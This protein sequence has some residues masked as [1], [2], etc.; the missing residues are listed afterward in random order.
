[1]LIALKKDKIFIKKVM[2]YLKNN[3]N[4]PLY[5]FMET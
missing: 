1:M 4:K 5:G 2:F 3:K